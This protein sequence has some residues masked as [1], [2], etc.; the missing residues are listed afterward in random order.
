MMKVSNN[1]IIRRLTLRSLKANT[2]RNIVAI[3][4][5]ALTSVLFTT[6][7]TLGGNMLTSMQDATMRQVGMNSHVG[8]KMITQEEYNR[9]AAVPSVRDISYNIIVGVGENDALKK[10]QTEIRYS[11]DDS[12]KWNF[13]YPEVGAMPQGEL[14]IACSTI[15]LDLLGVPHEI[16]QLVPLT[17]TANGVTYSKPFTLCGYWTGDPVMAAQQAWVSRI[18]SDQV[19]PVPTISFRQTQ[20]IDYE[21]YIS[22]AIWFSNS[23]NLEDKANQLLN[24]AGFAP[25][26]IDIG[27]NWA[28]MGG[29]LDPTTVII[30]VFVLVLILLSGYLIIYSIFTISVTADIHFFGLLKTIGTTGKQLRRIV[31]RQALFL[32]AFGIPLGLLLGWLSGLALTPALIRMTT[33]GENFHTTANPLIFIFAA[34]FSLLTVFVSCQKPSRIAAKVSPVEAVHF[35]DKSAVKRKAKRSGKVTTVSMAWSNTW[36]TPKKLAII[37]LS[38]SL[39]MILLNSVFSVVKGFDM[40]AYLE[41]QAVS[42]FLV[43]DTTVLSLMASYTNYEGIT[44]EF[45]ADL[46]EQPGITGIGNIRCKENMH[47]LSDSAYENAL[48]AYDA[49][50]AQPDY[51]MESMQKV[52]DEHSTPVHIFGVNPFMAAKLTFRDKTVD[53]EKFL[54]G[55]YVF[56]GNFTG[57][58]DNDTYPYYTPGDKI[59]L[60]SGEGTV[61][62]YT[63]LGYADYPYVL[64]PRHSH[65]TD[66]NIILA[67]PQFQS[68]YGDTKPMVTIYD[69]DAASIPA[70]E[71]WT[72]NYC[73]NVNSDLSYTSRSTYEKEFETMSQSYM[74]IGGALSFILALI[75]ILNFTNSQV[76]S[77]FARRRE[78]AILQS[79]GLTGKQTKQMLF[80]EGAFHAALTVLFT[81]TVGLGIGYLIMKVIAGEIWFFK[82]SFTFAPSLYC[83]LPLL[84]ICAAVP[85]ICYRRLSRESVVERLKVE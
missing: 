36:R 71:L 30:V 51:Y 10:S 27:I 61:K 19:A 28:Y 64:T 11:E 85:L 57:N 31:R 22:A 45:L 43:A 4:A 53:Y 23:L 35:T 65:L 26:E 72:V 79:I 39:S 76:T 21:G 68:L 12:A 16:G 60:D 46:S 41:G 62:E 42:D 70:L 74:M 34:V 58:D 75:G 44:D 82:S 2:L 77:I 59:T 84:V 52:K 14:D 83:I 48:R 1:M 63:V 37:V 33:M 56:V 6:I 5:I 8:A 13:S 66:I 50:G 15:T 25:N 40:D 17:F 67:E 9:I 7:F 20:L 55:D 38:L 29:A 54:S 3:I 80:F 18:F 81:V 24:E 78:L 47:T 49:I 32:S 73:E 69:A